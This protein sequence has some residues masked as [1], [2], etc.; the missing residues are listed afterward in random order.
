MHIA[1]VQD[2]HRLQ[3]RYRQAADEIGVRPHVGAEAVLPDG[4]R[5]ELGAMI[6][7][8]CSGDE[9]GGGERCTHAAARVRPIDNTRSYGASIADSLVEESMT[10]C[11]AEDERADANA[12]TPACVASLA[13]MYG[14]VTAVGK[15]GPVVDPAPLASTMRVGICRW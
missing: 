12:R 2:P 4:M 1:V 14:L 6:R 15:V 8:R 9:V 3:P 11:L 13:A 5:C 7:V 10:L